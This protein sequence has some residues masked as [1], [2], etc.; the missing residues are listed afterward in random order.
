M[1]TEAFFRTKQDAEVKPCRR[2]IAETIL[3]AEAN[4]NTNESL[5]VV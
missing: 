3:M 1:R 5:K 4:R 2:K